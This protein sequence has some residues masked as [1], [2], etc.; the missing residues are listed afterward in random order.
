M[1]FSNLKGNS[2]RLSS[3]PKSSV[4]FLIQIFMESSA[5]QVSDFDLFNS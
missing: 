1:P 5:F 3:V 2:G 4:R